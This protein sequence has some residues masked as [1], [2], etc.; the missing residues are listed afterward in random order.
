MH[1]VL[2]TCG[3]L[4]KVRKWFF[5]TA[6]IIFQTWFS[7]FRLGSIF[8]YYIYKLFTKTPNSIR[9]RKENIRIHVGR[10]ISGST[11]GINRHRISIQIR[12]LLNSHEGDFR[13]VGFRLLRSFHAFCVV[14]FDRNNY[15]FRKPRLTGV[16]LTS[17]T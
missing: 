14:N 17:V 12:I 3:I 13:L 4:S 8:P 2:G 7:I 11:W 5:R 10:G 15:F 16:L 9:K 6:H 1:T